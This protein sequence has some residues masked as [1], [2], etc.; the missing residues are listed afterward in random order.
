MR[1]AFTAAL[2]A[3]AVGSSSGVPVSAQDGPNGF[4]TAL[5]SVPDTP[6]IRQ[7]LVSW[8]DY[9]TLLGSREG[10]AHPASFAALLEQL[11]ARDPAARL[12]VAALNGAAS[13]SGRLLRYLLSGGAEWPRMVG[14]DFTDVRS[15]L[16]FGQPPGDGIVLQG[17]F[18]P[19]RIGAALS[20]RDFASTD[21]GRFVLWC[22][23]DGCD[24]GLEQDLAG[25]DPAD[26]FGGDLGRRQ[27]LAVSA[28]TLLS[29]AAISTIDGML[30]ATGDAAPSLAD[31]GSYAAVAEALDGEGALIQATLVPGTELLFD[32]ILVFGQASS[33]DEIRDRLVELAADFEPI[34]P[35]SLLGIGDGATDTEQVVTL[36]LAYPTLAD[37]QVAADVL[38]RRLDTMTSLRTARPWKELLDERGVGPIDARAVERADGAGALALLTLRAPLAGPDGDPDTGSV[39]PSS[40]LYRL[41]V[42]MIESRDVAWLAPSLPTQN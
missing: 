25:R 13:G 31:D 41:F 21:A 10:A 28:D 16:A 36:A 23:S 38:P 30:A 39:A 26:P 1:R 8:I 15:E 14:F 7:Q 24:K 42:Q 33:P 17:E 3:L 37:A 34:P 40:M 19:D 20:T 4:T 2:L 18:D 27:P 32:P 5:D 29:S 12:W 35:S 11:D 6:D 9:D 22:R